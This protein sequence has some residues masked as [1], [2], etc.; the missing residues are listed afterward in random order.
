M[1]AYEDAS[2]NALYPTMQIAGTDEDNG[3][4]PTMPVEH[5][6]THAGRVFSKGITLTVADTK[7]G[8]VKLTTPAAAAVKAA[9]TT[10]MTNA[11]ADPTYTAVTA[12]TAGNGIS[13]T[14]VNPGV[15]GSALAVSVADGTK[16]IVVSL[17]TGPAVAA[18]ATI[19]E[20]VYTA[21]AAGVQGNN[22]TVAHVTSGNYTRPSVT[23]AN[24]VITVALGTTS[25]GVANSPSGA[26]RDLVNNDPAA[27]A[28]VTAA[29][30]TSDVTLAAAASAT[31]LASGAAGGAIT[32]TCTQLVAAVNAHPVAGALV[33]ATA[34]GTGAGVVNAVSVASLASGADADVI[35]LKSISVA[36]TA[37]VTVTLN[38][39]GTVTGSESTI[40]PLNRNRN[41]AAAKTPHVVVKTCA[42][43][44]LGGSPTA[45][46][47]AY[48]PA[49]GAGANRVGAATTITDEWVLKP[50]TD[51]IL[52]IANAS[53]GAAVVNLGV[54]Y[55][56]VVS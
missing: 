39:G 12:G 20:V 43:A 49:G 50:A 4:I 41:L 19:G 18:S 56:E 27:S 3:G 47:T 5:A 52:G 28:L 2:G 16:A 7:T 14:H 33:L 44:T 32:T 13:V 36:S 10:N 40:V 31:H 29:V 23:V 24:N 6:L 11:N 26:I 46:D 55:Y 48:V 53:G 35:H 8:S 25:A 9:L 30:A 51:Y 37:A 21:K 15:A 42:D 22:I 38:E 54:L 17:A 34:E 1:A 45:L